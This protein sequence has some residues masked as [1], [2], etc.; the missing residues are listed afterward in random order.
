MT[1]EQ[2]L[3]DMSLQ[4]SGFDVQSTRAMKRREMIEQ[5]P[6]SLDGRATVLEVKRF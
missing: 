2:T 1:S 5:T 4:A 3:I 6:L